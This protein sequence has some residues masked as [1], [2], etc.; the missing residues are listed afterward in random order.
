[1]TGLAS[2]FH[3]SSLYARKVITLTIL[4]CLLGVA[5]Q[6]QLKFNK[7]DFD[8]GKG[9]VSVAAAD[10][11]R[12]GFLDVVTANSRNNCIT[13]LINNG[14]STFDRRTDYPAG[15][16]PFA[17]VTADFNHDGFC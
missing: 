11:N 7:S 6:A 10:F 3:S 16:K 15:K 9:P 17:V 1:M 13:V 4:F 14:N 8:T 5:A 12:D 2:S